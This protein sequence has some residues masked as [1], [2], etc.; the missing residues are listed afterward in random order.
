[1]ERVH[2]KDHLLQRTAGDETDEEGVIL[3][4]RLSI[5]LEPGARRKP[6]Y[7][8]RDV[9]KGGLDTAPGQCVLESLRMP[10]P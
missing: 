1:M 4:Q 2:A 10:A 8:L 5:N 3:L 9:K 6:S 7:Q